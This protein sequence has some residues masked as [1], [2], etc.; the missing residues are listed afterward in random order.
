[1]SQQIKTEDAILLDENICQVAS[2]CLFFLLQFC[3]VVSSFV[4]HYLALHLF[5]LCPNC[6][7]LA[8]IVCTL[9][10]V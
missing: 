8:F 3:R 9:F 10:P 6:P 1:M 7:I 2:Y 5:S 4:L